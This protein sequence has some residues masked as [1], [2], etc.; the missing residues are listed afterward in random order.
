MDEA[1]KNVIYYDCLHYG[2]VALHKLKSH[3]HVHHL[4]DPSHDTKMLLENA[5]GVFAPLGYRF[6]KEKIDC[7]PN[8]RVIMSNTTGHP[9]IDVDYAKEKGIKVACLKFDQQFLSSITPTAELAFGLII[10]LTRRIIPASQSVLLGEWERWPFAGQSMLSRMS[11]GIVGLGRLGSL[12]ASY[13]NVFG[14]SVFFYDPFVADQGK[15]GPK[16][17]K[18]LE[19]L[20]S[21]S[22][23][24]SVHAPHEPETEKLISSDILQ[25]LPSGAFVVNTARGE[26]IDWDA[27]LELLKCGHIAGAAMD[28]FPNEY[29]ADF[30]IEREAPE[31]LSYAR[32]NDNLIFTPHIGGSTHDAWEATQL[33]TVDMAIEL[34]T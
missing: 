11:L 24:L 34:I 26:L 25:A 23:V 19:Q 16:K 22:D 31:L 9:H 12:V 20:A 1:V 10:S 33:R 28:V 8:L 17:C 13:G 4:P 7:C 15:D 3:F 5:F 27:L 29:S 32:Q 14:M 21:V 2:D 18:S 6:S 30:D